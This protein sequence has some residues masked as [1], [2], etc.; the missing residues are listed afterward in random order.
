MRSRSEHTTKGGIHNPAIGV[1]LGTILL[2]WANSI[3]P[4]TFISKVLLCS[5]PFISVLID[6]LSNELTR[7]ILKKSQQRNFSRARKEIQICLDNKHTSEEHKQNLVK[8]M[9][10]IELQKINCICG[11]EKE[12]VEKGKK[13]N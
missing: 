13:N 8:K 2:L 6:K 7:W 1:L 9:E 12:Y 3:T 5:S 4:P 11:E 10:S